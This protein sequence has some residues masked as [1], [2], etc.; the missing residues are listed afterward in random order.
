[1]LNVECQILK[2]LKEECK[3]LQNAKQRCV[4]IMEL[5]HAMSVNHCNTRCWKSC[6]T[7]LKIA[8]EVLIVSHCSKLLILNLKKASHGLSPFFAVRA[9]RMLIDHT[10]KCNKTTRSFVKVQRWFK[11]SAL[12][13]L[14]ATVF[15]AANTYQNHLHCPGFERIILKNVKEISASQSH[16]LWQLQLS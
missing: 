3:I 1:M 13:I 9:L 15:L 11:N 8:V 4:T 10:S 5:N 16:S 2:M 6:W 14:V 7:F 12:Y